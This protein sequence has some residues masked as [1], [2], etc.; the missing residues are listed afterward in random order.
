MEK[1]A[2]DDIVNLLLR[3][4]EM[5]DRR[6]REFDTSDRALWAQ[7]FDQLRDELQRHEKA[8]ET[9]LYPAL[10]AIPGGAVIADARLAEQ[11]EAAHMLD[12]LDTLDAD[13]A[14]FTAAL[15]EMRNAVIAHAKRE[16][17]EAFPFLEGAESGERLMDLGAAYRQAKERAV[18]TR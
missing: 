7:I 4:H 13:T 18:V 1:P 14:D 16:E 15:I 6:F 5:L 8:E 2:P 3:D 11:Q 17:R 12:H 9:V 10:R